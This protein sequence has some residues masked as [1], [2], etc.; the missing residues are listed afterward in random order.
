[1]ELGALICKPKNPSCLLCPLRSECVALATGRVD[2]FPRAKEKKATRELQIPLYLI[3]DRQGRMLMR[4]ESGALMHAMYHLPH[5]NTSLLGGHSLDAEPRD[6]LGSFRH[7]VTTRK[8]EFTVYTADVRRLRD[9]G[10][11]YEWIDPEKLDAVPHPSYVR[12]AIAVWRAG[13]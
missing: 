9:S 5:G 1:M 11:D 7:T 12:K 8:I 3:V 10:G 6:R 13:L 2:E 4:R